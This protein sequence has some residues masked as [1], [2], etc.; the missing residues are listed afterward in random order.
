MKKYLIK[1]PIYKSGDIL[2]YTNPISK[3]ESIVILVRRYDIKPQHRVA[4]WYKEHPNGTKEL[5]A[6]EEEFSPIDSEEFS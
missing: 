1:N 4:W 5:G 3:K 2:R 6:P